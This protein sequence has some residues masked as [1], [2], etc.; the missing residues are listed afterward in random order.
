M[1]KLP[2]FRRRLVLTPRRVVSELLAEPAHLPLQRLPRLRRERAEVCLELPGG[3]DVMPPILARDV[4]QRA[5]VPAEP[6]QRFAH[7]M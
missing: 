2:Q 3:V 1:V 7:G 6:R 5:A 4:T